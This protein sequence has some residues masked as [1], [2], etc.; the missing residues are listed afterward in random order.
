MA[1]L[2]APALELRLLNGATM[3]VGAA[4]AV[5]LL[6][7]AALALARSPWL[8]LRAIVIDG[9]VRRV[10]VATL[11][12]YGLPRIAGNFVAVDL[13]DAGRAFERAPW[14]RRASVRRTWPD[15]LTVTVE[16]HR[17]VAL[18]RARTGDDRLVN[19]HGEVFEANVGDVDDEDLPLFE[20]PG[21]AAAPAV[22]ALHRRLQPLFDGA[23]LPIAGL[24]LSPRGGWRATLEDGASVEL[25]RGSDDEIVARARGFTATIEAVSD[26]FDTELL[27]ADLRHADGYA[28]RLRHVTTPTPTPPANPARRP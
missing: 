16:E 23:G 11:R 9:E 27:R 8:P 20:A 1:A 18:W 17:P 22:L 10:S 6:W 12:A 13:D 28:V 5:V 14:V 7:V 24:A 26:H 3:A 21:D 2:I 19:D 25:G 15:R 4:A